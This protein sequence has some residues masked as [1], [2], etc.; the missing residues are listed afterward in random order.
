M[1]VLV[2]AAQGVNKRFLSLPFV[3]PLFL[4]HLWMSIV[5]ALVVLSLFYIN[6]IPTLF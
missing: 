4:F 2:H 6:I 5:A 1:L 3:V